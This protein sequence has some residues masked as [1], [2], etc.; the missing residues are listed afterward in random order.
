MKQTKIVK[1]LE[2]KRETVRTLVMKTGLRTGDADPDHKGPVTPGSVSTDGGGRDVK[3]ASEVAQP[4][5]ITPSGGQVFGVD[6]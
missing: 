4:T 5:V 3:S 1:R 2:L 6:G